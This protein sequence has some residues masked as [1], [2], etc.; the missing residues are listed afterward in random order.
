MSW[1]PRVL[2]AA[3]LAAFACEVEEASM[4]EVAVRIEPPVRASSFPAQVLIAFDSSGSGFAAFRVGFLCAPDAPFFTTVTFTAPERAPDSVDAF[5][6]PVVPGSAF[7]CGPLAT[8]QRVPFSSA[9]GGASRTSASFVVV[10][11]CGT[12]DARVAT[13][14]IGSQP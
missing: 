1:R 13:V 4:L 12:G 11:G 5:V 9:T 3:V 7:T 10:G 8:P 6:L 14:V 2:L